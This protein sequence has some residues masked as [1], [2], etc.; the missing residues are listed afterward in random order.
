MRP[1]NRLVMLH[2]SDAC[3]RVSTCDVIAKC[4][5]SKDRCQESVVMC[6]YGIL[7]SQFSPCLVAVW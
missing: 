7:Y 5:A 1:N 2:Y 4:E 3:C 6:R